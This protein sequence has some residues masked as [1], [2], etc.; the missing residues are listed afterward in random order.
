MSAIALDF[1]IVANGTFVGASSVSL[2]GTF[3]GTLTADSAGILKTFAINGTDVLVT[4]LFEQKGADNKLT[5]A[6]AYGSPSGWLL[7]NIGPLQSLPAQV[8][9]WYTNST[10][11]LGLTSNGTL[12]VSVAITAHTTSAL[13]LLMSDFSTSITALPTPDLTL[14]LTA[15]ATANTIRTLLQNVAISLTPSNATTLGWS[16]TTTNLATVSNQLQTYV[17]TLAILKAVNVT[18]AVAFTSDLTAVGP[19]DLVQV[20]IGLNLSVTDLTNTTT[21]SPY[22]RK[23]LCL[24]IT[25]NIV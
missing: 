11:T 7:N 21:S 15:L 25:R 20:F 3:S 4:S 12:T 5:A 9:L 17:R 18:T 8:K 23:L 22:A 2:N 24:N 16:L 14:S 13:A 6:P 1:T 10:W 19:G